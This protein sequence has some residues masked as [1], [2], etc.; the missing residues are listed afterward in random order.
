MGESDGD[1]S[2][3]PYGDERDRNPDFRIAKIS[4]DRYG[5][6]VVMRLGA[7]DGMPVRYKPE[8]AEKI[9]DRLD[10]VIREVQDS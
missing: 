6:D 5:E 7:Q 2:D 9:R 1:S 8:A 3:T 10:E 4:T